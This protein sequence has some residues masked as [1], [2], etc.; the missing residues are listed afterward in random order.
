MKQMSEQIKYTYEN[1]ASNYLFKQV[2]S[3]CNTK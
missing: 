2:S 3:I 1:S